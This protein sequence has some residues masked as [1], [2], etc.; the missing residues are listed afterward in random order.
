MDIEEFIK[1]GTHREI[2]HNTPWQEISLWLKYWGFS[3]SQYDNLPNHLKEVLH[4]SICEPIKPT[5]DLQRRDLIRAIFSIKSAVA[6]RESFEP[7]DLIMLDEQKK[8]RPLSE[9]EKKD[10]L[11]KY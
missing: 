5:T 11:S 7:I 6:G 1:K 2:K 8:L 9:K 3:Y 4:N 10:F